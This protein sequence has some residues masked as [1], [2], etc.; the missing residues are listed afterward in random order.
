MDITSC[1][2]MHLARLFSY[3]FALHARV[4]YLIERDERERRG[5]ED[6]DPSSGA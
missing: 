1:L 5:A 3:F 2:T 6:R 4:L